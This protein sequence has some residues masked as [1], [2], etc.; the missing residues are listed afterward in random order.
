MAI[1]EQ[2]EAQL[3]S[4][5]E[6]LAKSI[7]LGDAMDKSLSSIFSATS[8]LPSRNYDYWER[9]IRWELHR[10]KNNFKPPIWRFWSKPVDLIPWVDLCSE[11]G[12][13]RER[14]LQDITVGA[15]NAFFFA[16]AF[17]RLNDW[18]PQVRFA[19]KENILRIAQSTDSSIVASVLVKLLPNW[20]S[21]SRMDEDSKTHLLRIISNPNIKNTIISKVL[22]DPVGP[23]GFIFSQLSRSEL[24]DAY[25]DEI[26]GHAIQPSVRARAYQALLDG[27]FT[28]V[29]GRKWEWTDVRYCKGSFK[30]IFG[31]RPA[32]PGRDKIEMLSAASIDRSAAVRKIVADFLIRE[33]KNEIPSNELGTLINRL[34]TDKSPSVAERGQYAQKKLQTLQLQCQNSDS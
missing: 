11:S 23:M 4:A 20:N 17:R 5:I 32:N 6:E 25:L 15:P 16:I 9:F 34:A 22:H 13:K 26:A 12:F 8:N 14:A 33:I 28:W 24:F 10:A 19:A 2:Y 1:P 30:T 3:L 7:A 18:V 31:S 27:K 29:S 21:W